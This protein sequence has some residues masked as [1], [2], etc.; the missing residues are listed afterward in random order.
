MSEAAAPTDPDRGLSQAEAQRRLALAGPNRLPQPERRSLLRIAANVLREPMLLLLLAAASLYLVLGDTGEALLLAASVLLVIAITVRQEQRS[1]QALQALRELGTPQARVLRDGEIRR[2]ATEAIVPGDIVLVAEGDRVPAD[3]RLLE[4]E[5]LQLDESLLTGESAPVARA[6]GAGDDSLIRASTLVSSGHGRAEIVATGTRT[7]VGRIGKALNAIQPG[8]TPLQAQMRRVVM[9]FAI[10]SFL[11]SVLLAGLHYVVRGDAFASLLAGITLAMATIPEEFPVVLS[12]FLA[13][14][15]WRMA[16][17]KVLVRRAAAIETLGAI[18]VLCSDKTGTLTE[19]RMAVAALVPAGSGGSEGA[20]AESPARLQLLRVASA[21]SRADSFDPMDRALRQRLAESGQASE[22]GA[23]LREYPLSSQRPAVAHAWQSGDGVWLACKGAPETVAGFCALD[24]KARAHVSEQLQA[25]AAKGLRVLGV[26]SA[27]LASGQAMPDALEDAGMTWLGLVAF[28]DPLRASAGAAIA[29]AQAAGVRVLMLTGDHAATAGSIAGQAGLPA[30]GTVLTGS[31][32]DA[33]DDTALVAAIARCSVYAR[34]RP[35]QKLR[36]VQ[37]LRARGEVVGMTGDGVNDAPALAAA[38]VGIAMGGRGT[39]VARESA[40]IV[41]LDDDFASIVR[42]LRMGRAI[43]DNIR[44]AMR[45]ILAVH[46]PI[47]GL[48]MLPLLTGS[49]LILMPVHVVF[50]EL[51]IDPACSIVFEREPP[52]ADLMQRP[53]RP[54][55]EGLFGWKELTASL[56]QGLAMLL[57]VVAI[58]TWALRLLGL[59]HP[60]A[61]AL[62]F[63]ALVAGNLGL[64]LL[65]RAGDGLRQ[66]LQLPNRALWWVA[67][68]ALCTLTVVTQAPSPAAWFGFA[69]PPASA[70]LLAVLLP[71]VAAPALALLRRRS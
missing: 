5:H 17:H 7:A 30:A 16:R 63:T 21:A 8:A 41:L 26:A 56:A 40:D 42:A 19:N 15:A 60:Q 70:W 1:E 54:A 36:L 46:V 22:P 71:L 35:E 31:D 20:A 28:A 10:A 39:D 49:P 53:P 23:A 29:E 50:L 64:I 43:Y 55:A 44:R 58:H 52:V 13:L 57:L 24:A 65:Y 61:A 27:R 51:I 6:P 2:L 45:Y 18:S 67:G 38:H 37:A 12:V 69:P 48:A 33:L 68:M 4:S 62:A 59:P 32:I 3:G 34:V 66:R 47:T 11:A 9:I 14:G 25:L